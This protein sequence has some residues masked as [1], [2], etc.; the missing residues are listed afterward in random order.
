MYFFQVKEL[1][2]QSAGWLCDKEM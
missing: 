1:Q 2:K